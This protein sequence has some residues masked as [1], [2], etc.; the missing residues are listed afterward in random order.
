MRLFILGVEPDLDRY[1]LWNVGETRPAL[2]GSRTDLSDAPGSV[3]TDADFDRAATDGVYEV[4]STRTP[5][6]WH[7]DDEDGIQIG[8]HAIRR[9]DLGSMLDRLD[10]NPD[11]P[12]LTDLFMPDDDGGDDQD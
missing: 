3:V 1:V 9:E 2:W 12:D 10:E 5:G 11:D 8:D 6:Y 4:G 7:W